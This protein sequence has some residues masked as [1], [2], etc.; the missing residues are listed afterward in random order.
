MPT[1]TKPRREMPPAAL[2]LVAARFRVL[3]E[4]NRLRLL[5]ELQEQERCVNEL[6]E[7]TGLTQANVSRHLQALMQSGLLSRRKAGLQVFYGIAEPKIFEL[8]DLVCGSLSERMK[9]QA[10]FFEK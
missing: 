3:G 5:A 9:S 2:E 6:V 4:P 7:A 8:C 10:A 1:K